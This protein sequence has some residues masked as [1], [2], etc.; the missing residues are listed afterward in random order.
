[1]QIKITNYGCYFGGKHI[2]PKTIVD[3]P[4]VPPKWEGKCEVIKEEQPEQPEKKQVKK[5]RKKTEV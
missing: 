2:M 4:Q 3:L 5:A 1:M